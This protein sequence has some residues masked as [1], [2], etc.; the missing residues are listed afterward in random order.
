MGNL[1][2][3]ARRAVVIGAGIGGL[4][5]ATVL[6]D[7]FKEVILL[8]RDELPP[9]PLPRAVGRHLQASFQ[10]AAISWITSNGQRLTVVAG[11]PATMTPSWPMSAAPRCGLVLQPERCLAG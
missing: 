3:T 9:G 5:A 11:G 2:F 7:H 10:R 1:S 6:A 8:E 4:T